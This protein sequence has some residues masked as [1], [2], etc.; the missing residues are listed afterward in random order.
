MRFFFLVENRTCGCKI[1]QK[2]I[3][4]LDQKLR[5]FFITKTLGK[6]SAVLLSVFVSYDTEFKKSMGLTSHFFYAKKSLSIIYLAKKYVLFQKR[7]F[8]S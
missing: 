3:T 8:I 1:R 5:L 4:T 6:P 7:G 2:K